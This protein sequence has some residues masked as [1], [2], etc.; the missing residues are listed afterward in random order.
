[1]FWL[2]EALVSL[3]FARAIVQ[4]EK[5]FKKISKPFRKSEKWVPYPT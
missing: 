2:Y 1:M 5:K 3:K 4:P